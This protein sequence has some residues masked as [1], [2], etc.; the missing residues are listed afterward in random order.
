MGDVAVSTQTSEIALTLPGPRKSRAPRRAS[1]AAVVET[2]ALRDLALFSPVDDAT[3]AR[4]APEIKVEQYEDGA[5]IFRQGDPVAAVVVILR[6][7]VKLL[8][9]AAS[10]DETLIGIRSD[11]ATVGEPPTLGNEICRVSAEAIGPTSV[12]KIPAARFTRLMKESPSLSAAVVE[13]ARDKIALLI[14]EIESLKAQNADQ[15]L[16]SFILALCP[17]GLDQCRFRLPYD[18]RLIA[19]QLGVKQ[20]TL[21]RAFAKLRD[22]GVRTET[23]DV[24]V[25]SVSRLA[26]QCQHLGRATR[27]VASGKD[28][29]RRDDAA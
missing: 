14:G 18:K 6:G 3:L 11:G 1:R 20:E 13:D 16:A 12:L 22:Y 8:R 10:G 19:A 7:F 23:R 5:V 9:I 21:S 17:P 4:L 24:L 15:R 25:E 27:D 2:P 28:A 29:P 26:T